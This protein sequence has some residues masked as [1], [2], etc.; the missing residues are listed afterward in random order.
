MLDLI[1]TYIIEKQEPTVYFA[2][3]RRTLR[4]IIKGVAIAVVLTSVA[5]GAPFDN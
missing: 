1:N 4:R 5:L 2:G 3:R